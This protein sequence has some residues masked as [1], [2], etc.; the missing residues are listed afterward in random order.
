MDLFRKKFKILLKISL[1]FTF[2]LGF[3]VYVDQLCAQDNK[4][5][6]SS[7]DKS[8]RI[9]HVLIKGNENVS[10]E[11][12]L[13]YIGFD[14][15]VYSDVLNKAILNRLYTSGFFE[16]AKVTFKKNSLYIS[17]MENKLINQISFEGNK[18]ISSEDIKKYITSQEN[19]F[20]QKYNVTMDLNLMHA[21]YK[22]KG[23][24]GTEISYKLIPKKH[25]KSLYDLVFYIKEK[26]SVKIKKIIFLGN[27]NYLSSDLEAIIHS[28]SK[29][30]LFS[31]SYSENFM[32]LDK[33]LLYQFYNSK[34]YIN[35]TIN[36][37]TVIFSP[38]EGDTI[39]YSIYEGEPYFVGN[40]SI[41]LDKPSVNFEK[42]VLLQDIKIGYGDPFNV[43]MLKSAEN[44]VRE[45]LKKLGYFNFDVDYHTERDEHN[46]LIDIHFEVK[47]LEEN[48]FVQDVDILGNKITQ[49]RTIR[50]RI[51]L[52]D[53]DLLNLDLLG[54]SSNRI[55]RLP[56][57][58][59]VNNKVFSSGN[60]QRK[61]VAFSVQD[62]DRTELNLG[63]GYGTDGISGTASLLERNFLGRGILGSGYIT[64][65]GKDN[66]KL[67]FFGEKTN[68]LM[69]DSSFGAGLSISESS[70][71][72]GGNKFV[73]GDNLQNYDKKSKEV[74]TYQ[75]F[76][77]SKNLSHR[78]QYTLEFINASTS[79]TLYAVRK[80]MGVF[81]SSKLSYTISYGR[82]NYTQLDN[83]LVKSGIS[84]TSI[85]DFEGLG[86]NIGQMRNTLGF[87]YIKPY[88]KNRFSL[89][90]IAL[91]GRM[92]PFLG[93]NV[94]IFDR[95]NL[96]GEHLR[97]F[98]Y[99]GVGPY[100]ETAQAY[101]DG[102]AE[103]IGGN[104]HY[105]FSVDAHFPIK[106][107]SK[108]FGISPFVFLDSGSVWGVDK[109]EH[110]DKIEDEHYFRAS[111]GFGF[112][113]RAPSIPLLEFGFGF[114]IKKHKSDSE[115][116][117]YFKM[118]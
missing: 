28:K 27:K 69:K 96:G 37:S 8:F 51:L 104:N 113:I 49:D 19:S 14:L 21:L 115:T 66:Y 56:F 60:I 54:Y 117:F 16:Q 90:F 83:S 53:L 64:L 71:K 67:G 40:I 29:R 12:I 15:D 74:Y 88:S 111:Y 31:T 48:F 78:L 34:G 109:S 68:F 99:R 33:M 97:G 98:T 11:T 2:F 76:N 13:S 41:S 4:K 22:E 103:H 81:T 47:Q 20:V 63:L 26:N 23:F 5:V 38:L 58:Q 118:S 1:L 114:P 57:I 7:V 25:H 110:K 86:G 112:V 73:I 85:N 50:S 44:V 93:Q 108:H 91:A 87:E 116:S 18:K 46:K 82:N 61:N 92:T 102:Q 36:S 72:E 75:S 39:I 95:F 52:H 101:G 42:D 62:L 17:V 80:D 106:T 59:G 30:Y 45:N 10:R 94:R 55:D 77:T 24:F 107:S 105:R 84:I 43:D 3:F 70:S 79:S 32:S 65:H 89:K 9:D 100:L 6:N 35:F